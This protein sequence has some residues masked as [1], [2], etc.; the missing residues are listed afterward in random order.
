MTKRYFK[1][2]AESDLGEG[3]AYLEIS[4][5]WP[6]RQVEVYG[7]RWRWGD[8]AHDEWLADQPFEALELTEEHAIPNEEFERVWQEA[9]RRPPS[10][11]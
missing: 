1:H 11:R 4:D 3:M 5:G 6:T 9:T 2:E 8:A 7:E 10:A